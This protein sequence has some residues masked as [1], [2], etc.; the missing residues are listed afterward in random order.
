MGLKLDGTHP[1]EQYISKSRHA[2]IHAEQNTS[3]IQVAIKVDF[4]SMA[5]AP[6]H[7][8]GVGSVVTPRTGFVSS[9]P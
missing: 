3:S 6:T 5:W 7:A 4:D 9:G 2:P 8:Q 1:T